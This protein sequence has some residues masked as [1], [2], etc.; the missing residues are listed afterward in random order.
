M[1]VKNINF[2][3]GNGRIFVKI[4]S[5]LDRSE[6][7]VN[8][9]EFLKIIIQDLKT[10]KEKDHI[11]G[12]LNEN[13]LKEQLGYYIFDKKLVSKKYPLHRLKFNK[14]LSSIE[15]VM[16]KTK[17]IFGKRNILIYIFPTNSYFIAKKMNGSSGFLAWKNIIHIHLHPA[18]NWEA[19]FK[20][21]FLH[22]LA[23]CLQNYYSY[24]M[25]LFDHLIADGLAEHFQ[26][27]LLNARRN[28]WTNAIS[29]KKAK[30]IFKKIKIDLDKTMKNSSSV[31]S[32]LFFGSEKYPLWAGYTIG[33]YLVEDY[34]KQNKNIAWRELFSQKPDNFK[35]KL[36]EWFND[37]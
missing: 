17:N 8:K 31:H 6:F 7:L 3:T 4:V 5:L 20:S 33:Y 12:F 13:R 30:K 24:E 23:H 19:S 2:V 29:K 36:K 1:D 34:L 9:K 11:G 37:R 10:L 28:P 32:E 15:Q 26:K 35:E 25:S 14:I 22:E 21:T 18:K 27:N 16:N